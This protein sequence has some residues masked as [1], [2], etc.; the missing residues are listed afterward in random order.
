METRIFVLDIQWILSHQ[1]VNNFEHKLGE[2][3]EW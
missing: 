1:F 2:R 3:L